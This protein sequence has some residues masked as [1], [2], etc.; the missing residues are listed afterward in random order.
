[1]LAPAISVC[2]VGS[3]RAELAKCLDSLRAQ[4]CPPSFE[5][6]VSLDDDPALV[7]TVRRSFPDARLCHASGLH[8]GAA[9]NDLVQRATGDLLLFIDDDVIAHPGLLARAARLAQQHPEISV[10]GGPNETP[11]DSTRFQ[12]VQ[13]AVLG[14]LAG[15]GPVRRRYGA[16]RAGTADE[17]W[18]ILCNL[19]VR[20][21][22]MRPFP[23]DII[24]AEENVL[25]A[26]LRHDGARMH[27]S[28]QLIVFHARRATARSFA[29]QMF[30]YGRGRGELIARSPRST[31]AAYLAP[32]ALL[33]YVLA[34]PLLVSS[35][36]PSWLFGAALYGGLVAAGAAR[37]ASTIAQ[38]RAWPLAARLIVLLHL[39]YG[40]GVIRGTLAR[41]H[42]RVRSAVRWE[43]DH[44]PIPVPDLADEAP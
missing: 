15:S 18:F 41:R 24:C 21:E 38:A 19:V 27:Y 23:E 5:L 43:E 2:V 42:I 1:M 34:L 35:G 17:R 22:A 7:T 8:P 36:G 25:L 11:P 31:R 6:L 16:H 10:F 20:R 37:V 3:R 28:P 30:K 4:E 33:L 29:T 32:S 13:G 12:F 44:A 9:R 26:A 39:S 40:A 14:S